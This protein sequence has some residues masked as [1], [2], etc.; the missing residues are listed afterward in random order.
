MVRNPGKFGKAKRGGGHA[1]SRH[2]ALDEDGVAAP[3]DKWQ[4]YYSS[5]NPIIG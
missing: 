2:L 3:T 5:V 4:V 1:F